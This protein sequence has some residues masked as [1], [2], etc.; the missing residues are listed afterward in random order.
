M[1]R[2]GT[3]PNTNQN[4]KLNSVRLISAL[5]C[6]ASRAGLCLTSALFVS[7]CWISFR[8]CNQTANGAP[9][10]TIPARHLN[11]YQL[12][13]AVLALNAD[14]KAEI[15]NVDSTSTSTPAPA[16]TTPAATTAA[17]PT[18]TSKVVEASN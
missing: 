13:R 5:L 17:A 7:L 12:Y 9:E 16:T 8:S 18:E 14:P 1:D 11:E 2:N 10:R 4:S 15:A 3:K 6:L